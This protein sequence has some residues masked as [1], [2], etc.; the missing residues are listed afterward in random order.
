MKK[1]LFIM[2]LTIFPAL[3]HGA[4][5]YVAKTGSNSN[6]GSAG[7]PFLTITRGLASLTSGDTLIVRA[8]AYDET[9]D[10]NVPS[11]VTLRSE[12]PRGASIR[13]S[14]RHSVLFIFQLRGSTNNITIDGF[15]FDA[16]LQTGLTQHIVLHDT[17]HDIT[18]QNCE[19]TGGINTGGPSNSMG[20]WDDFGV[21]RVLFR[22]NK[23]HDIGRG[24]ISSGTSVYGMYF[25]SQNSIVEANEFHH[26]SGMAIHQYCTIEG[27][28]NNNIIRNNVIHDNGSRGILLGSGG[29]NNLAHNNIFYGNGYGTGGAAIQVGGYGASSSDNKV[30]NNTI[31]GN[32]AECIKIGS[33][34]SGASGTIVQN[35]ICYGNGT[36]DITQ[37][38]SSGSVIDH[39]LLGVNPLF[40]NAASHDFRLQAGSPAID[41]GVAVGVLSSQQYNGTAPDL[42]ALEAGA[43]GQLP[44]PINLRLVVN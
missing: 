1:L 42:G 43:G 11:G 16:T 34:Y 41:A 39:N 30:Y 40:A 38:R 9:F 5:Y 13:P 14:D 32:T 20:Y 44:A 28:C 37:N 4:T 7:S 25:H 24:V 12:V 26:L 27:E 2:F 15:L 35:N 29:R 6:N 21:R 33:Q 8:G 17:V 10:N 36:D 3:A 19:I 18:I 22:Q 23:V 31:Y